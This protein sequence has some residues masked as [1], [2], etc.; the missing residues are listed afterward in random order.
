[1]LFVKIRHKR[2]ILGLIEGC[3]KIIM[4]DRNI[5]T[6]DALKESSKLGSWK[7]HRER[8]KF[9]SNLV[10]LWLSRVWEMPLMK[11]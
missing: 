4:C 2:E 7:S 5:L 6:E 10:A 3:I 8:T 1:M 11:G 9:I